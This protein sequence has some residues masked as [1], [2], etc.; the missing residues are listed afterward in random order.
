[1]YREN[2]IKQII[3]DYEYCRG[4]NDALTIAKLRAELNG[5]F[6]ERKRIMDLCISLG[7]QGKSLMDLYNNL[8]GLNGS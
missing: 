1:M 3:E 6:E 2:E 5:I 7:S 8:G 4:V